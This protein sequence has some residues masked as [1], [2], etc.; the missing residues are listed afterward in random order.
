MQNLGCTNV[1]TI[2]GRLTAHRWIVLVLIPALWI[3][4]FLFSTLSN[5]QRQRSQRGFSLVF[6]V[7]FV[8]LSFHRTHA[9]VQFLCMC[10]FHCTYPF[11]PFLLWLS[12]A[13]VV[14]WYSG[15]TE[16]PT[17]GQTA[18]SSTGVDIYIYI[19]NGIVIFKI[20][21]FGVRSFQ[22]DTA[23]AADFVCAFAFPEA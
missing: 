22:Q 14:V 2:A 4:G 12:T 23:T 17:V 8:H 9:F 18:H 19:I 21:R 10:V 20:V 13:T 1:S 6:Q 5:E 11:F 16:L 7:M 3:A 15:G